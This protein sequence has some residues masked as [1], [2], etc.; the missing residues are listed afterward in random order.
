TESLPA[1]ALVFG[2]PDCTVV[3]ANRLLLQ[4]TGSQSGQ[5]EG[6]HVSSITGEIRLPQA[7]DLQR[8]LS[9]GPQDDPAAGPF[10]LEVAPDGAQAFRALARFGAADGSGQHVLLTIQRR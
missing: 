8:W 1:P 2:L 9:Q 7:A 4:L 3:F 6:S 5:V 10:D